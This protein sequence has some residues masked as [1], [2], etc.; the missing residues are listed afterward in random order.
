MSQVAVFWP[1]LAHVLLVFV[2]YVV[3]A[4]RRQG[5]VLSGAARAADYKQRAS[6]PEASMTASNNLMN[7]FEAP[8]LLHVWCLAL[9]AIGGVSAVALVLA[10]LF[11]LSRYVHAW[12]HLTTNTLKHR[13]YAF[14]AGFLLLALMWLL[15]AWRLA[16]G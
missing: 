13:N 9:H 3:L 4:I 14:R 5:A 6:E 10:W 12:I 7:Q 8:V 11:V 15:F 1:M 16:F 2:V